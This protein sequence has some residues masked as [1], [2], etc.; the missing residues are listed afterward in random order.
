MVQERIQSI[1][2]LRG[3]TIIGMIFCAAIGYGSGLPAWMFHCQ[4]PPPDYTFHPEV[5]GI[6][7]V[8][9][10]FP[11]FIF[12]MGAAFPFALKKK[13]EAGRTVIPG[14]LRR[15]ITLVL[16]A[17]AIGNAEASHGSGAPDWM[18]LVFNL[19]VWGGFFAVLV[20]TGKKWIN[21][22]GVL[23][24]A[25][26]F[27]AERFVMKA[28]LSLDTSDIII[29]ILSTVALTGSLVWLLT[30]DNIKLRWLIWG[31]ILALKAVDSY[32]D[33]LKWANLPH[34]VDYIISPD[35]I[36][37]LLIAI[38]AS[39][40]GDLLL[41]GN[42]PACNDREHKIAPWMIAVATL[43]LQLV[44][45]YIRKVSVDIPMT[46]LLMAA[47]LGLTNKGHGTGNE[48][49]YIG[50]ALLLLGIFF[51]PLDGGIAKDNCNITY[52]LVSGGMAAIAASL[53]IDAEACGRS[54]GFLGKCGQNP[55]I[56]YTIVWFVIEPLLYAVGIMG[57]V[58]GLADGSVV[59][60]LLRGVFLTALMCLSTNLFTKHNLFWRT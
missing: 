37:Y 38:P 8:D 32:T 24:L 56:A 20:R 30:K 12:S 28:N 42:R 2:A 34:P 45:L 25:A 18:I 40:V 5:R 58:D 48:V 51:D 33:L 35:W 44:T 19:A 16:F 21:L 36:Q 57:F 50:Y 46:I 11:F 10:V 31:V 49:A 17:L 39:V 41:K 9:L 14:I 59:W 26:L 53:F 22:A 55:M 27:I 23:I 15:W 3:I 6:S 13:T 29:M 60:G 4:V 52:L 47:Y 43:L 7:W 54:F 1:D